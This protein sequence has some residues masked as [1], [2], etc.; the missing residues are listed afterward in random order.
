MT[1]DRG[2][3]LLETLVAFVIL[4]LIL[5]AAYAAMG[6]GVRLLERT[7]HRLTTLQI[8]E[9]VLATVGREAPIRPGTIRQETESGVISVR[10][11]PVASGSAVSRTTGIIMHDVTVRVEPEDGSAPVQLRT[12][13]SERAR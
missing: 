8:A 1:R 9:S 10:T 7:E 6:G 2:F 11:V 3:T 13:I 12:L 4:A 5:G